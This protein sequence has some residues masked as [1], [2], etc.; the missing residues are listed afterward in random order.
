[1]VALV[2][3]SLGLLTVSFRSNALD[4]VESAAATGLRPFEIAANRVARP[5]RD[6][7]DWTHGVFNAKS[8]NEKL[9]A[10]N[11][12]LRQLNAKLQGAFDENSFLHKELRY[13]QGPRFPKDYD[14]VAAR[15]LSSPSADDQS[16]TISAGRN[17]GIELDDVVLTHQG[18][19]GTVSKVLGTEA[20]VT[21]ITDPTSAV[22]AVDA[23]SLAA[24]G[25]LE[26]GT[27]PTTLVLDNVGKDK[28]QV[29]AGD[30]IM[31]AGSAPGPLQSLFPRSIPIGYVSSVS[32][33][34]T[35][36]YQ[37]I[38]VQPYV[39]LSSLQSVLILIPKKRSPAAHK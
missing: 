11:A 32:Q 37:D 16:V 13:V 20:R 39:D 29:G 5:F 31:T 34:D 8:Q 17:H 35:D 10:E 21:L 23:Q 24:V 3:L 27:G 9:R 12:R 28:P 4:P 33:T 26:H 1:V 22:R 2:V 14:E 6:A 7:A 30:M 36:I 18:L 38:Q 25:I 19:V 15:V